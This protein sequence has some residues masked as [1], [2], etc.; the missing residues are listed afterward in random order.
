MN[1]YP[2]A[3]LITLSLSEPFVSLQTYDEKHGKSQR[4]FLRKDA[5]ISQLGDDAEGSAT[6]LDLLNVCTVARVGN[7][8]RFNMLWLHGSYNND[9]SG[10]QQVFFVPV[11]KAAKVLTGE[12]VKHLSYTLEQMPKASIFFTQTAHKAIADPQ[13]E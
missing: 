1:I 13:T 5:L 9:V 10:Y 7:N 6:E 3:I 4:F 12:K 11:G 2:N 8:I